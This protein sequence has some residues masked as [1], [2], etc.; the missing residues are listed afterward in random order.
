MQDK[1]LLVLQETEDGSPTLYSPLFDECYHSTRGAFAESQHIYVDNGLAT[2]ACEGTIRILEYGFG[3]G[4]NFC[5]AARWAEENSKT[6]DYTTLEL[7]PVPE[8]IVDDVHLPEC[9]DTETIWRAAHK[10][11]WGIPSALASNIRLTKINTDFTQYTPMRSFYH[12]VFFD[13]FSPAHVPEQ[14][15]SDIFSKI[16]EALVPTGCLV[17]YSAR[18]TVKNALRSV[19]FHVHRRAGALGKHHML[20][21]EKVS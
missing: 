14:W 19:G 12:I 4:L 1:D 16:F 17:T 3:L 20:F 7:Y 15:G 21:A 2:L 11:P 8:S 18:G 9:S 13:A 6:I 10:I 5:V